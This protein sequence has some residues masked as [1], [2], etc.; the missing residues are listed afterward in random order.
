[1]YGAPPVCPGRGTVPVM[2]LLR[3]GS[4]V[5]YVRLRVC[6]SVCRDLVQMSG[7]VQ[8]YCTQ[9]FQGLSCGGGPRVLYSTVQPLGTLLIDHTVIRSLHVTH[10]SCSIL[11]P[12]MSH[13]LYSDMY[14][15]PEVATR[16]IESRLLSHVYNMRL[17]VSLRDWVTSHTSRAGHTYVHRQHALALSRL[18]PVVTWKTAPI[19]TTV[20]CDSP[21]VVLQV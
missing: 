7:L 15:D 12:Y 20:T 3:L 21:A 19:L 10:M 13:T 1:M 18:V 4:M 6:G 2:T 9:G 11:T 14:N 16:H 8:W 5:E 17:T